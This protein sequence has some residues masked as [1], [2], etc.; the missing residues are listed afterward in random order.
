MFP[1]ASSRDAHQPS[2]GKM[3]KNG[4]PKADNAASSNRVGDI[5]ACMICKWSVKS[6]VSM[7]YR[8]TACYSYL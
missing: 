2:S 8:I 6:F 5:E 3:D 7:I 4:R 1:S